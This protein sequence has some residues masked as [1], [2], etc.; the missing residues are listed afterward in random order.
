MRV[1][2][3]VV[4]QELERYETAE[5]GVLGPATSWTQFPGIRA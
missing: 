1:A 3:N 2:G 5:F 4:G